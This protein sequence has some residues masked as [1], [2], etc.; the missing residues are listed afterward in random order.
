M[1]QILNYLGVGGFALVFLSVF[2]EITPIKVNPIQWLGSRLFKVQTDKMDRIE[3]KIDEHIAQSYRNKILAFQNEC[4]NGQRHTQEQFD[5]VLDACEAYE[6]YTKANKMS[7]GKAKLAI[8]YIKRVYS[9][10]QDSRD[11]VNLV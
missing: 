2:V 8:D 7:N 11:F 4:L 3:K 9:K 1:S 5:E 10:C 6:E